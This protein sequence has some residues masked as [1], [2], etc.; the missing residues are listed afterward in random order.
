MNGALSCI[1]C[2]AIPQK[3]HGRAFSSP[4]N[5][6]QIPLKTQRFS[7]DKTPAARGPPGSATGGR[8]L[9]SHNLI[10]WSAL[11]E[12]SVLP[13]GVRAMENTGPSRPVKVAVFLFVPKVQSL[14]VLSAL[15]DAIDLPSGKNT[16]QNTAAECPFS[17]TMFSPVDTR[18]NRTVLSRPADANSSPSGLNATP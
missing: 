13:L 8:S 17:V 5:G 1:H 7:G 9:N 6:P 11:P 15:L 3:T 14:I 12:A 18:H 4:K 2:P 16:T 10:V